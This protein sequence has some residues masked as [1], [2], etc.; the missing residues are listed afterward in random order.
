MAKSQGS[1]RGWWWWLAD[2]LAALLLVTLGLWM[3]VAGH[4]LMTCP[5]TQG[6]LGWSVLT[7]LAIPL[8]L[9]WTLL[10]WLGFPFLLTFQEPLASRRRFAVFASWLLSTGAGIAVIVMVTSRILEIRSRCGFGF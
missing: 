4:T 7:I 2:Y 9:S 5:S 6:W 8:V 10:L 1:E 3:S